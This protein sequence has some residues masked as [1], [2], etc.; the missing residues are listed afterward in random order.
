MTTAPFVNADRLG[1]DPEHVAERRR[2]ITAQMA[3]VAKRSEAG[4]L[5]ELRR[6]VIDCDDLLG[7]A[8]ALTA[9]G[10]VTRTAGPTWEQRARIAAVLVVGLPLVTG[11]AIAAARLITA[12]A[13][14]AGSLFY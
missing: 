4:E 2:Q 14:W 5:I 6:Q 7:Q 8:D 10:T 9:G 3:I 11:A 1:Q 12:L 13:E